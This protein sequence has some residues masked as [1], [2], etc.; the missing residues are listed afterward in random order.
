MNLLHLTEDQRLGYSGGMALYVA[1]YNSFLLLFEI[2]LP[3]DVM[4]KTIHYSI[5][6]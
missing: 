1:H 6:N 4:I 2:M 3:A 5:L